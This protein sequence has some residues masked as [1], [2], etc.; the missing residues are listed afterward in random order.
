VRVVVGAAFSTQ[1]QQAQQAYTEMMRANPNLTPAIGPLWAQ[2]LDVPHADKLAQVLTAMAP[3]EVQ[4][5]L[6]PQDN[7]PTSEQLMAQLEQMKAALQ[8]AL[9]VA[10]EVQQE[11]AQL[12]AEA[13]AKAAEMQIKA[14]EVGVKEYDAQT[15]RMTAEN[16]AQQQ[17][18]QL[19]LAEQEPPEQPEMPEEAEPEEKPEPPAPQPIV[20][21]VNVDARQPTNGT[22]HVLL[23][24]DELG[25]VVGGSVVPDEMMNEGL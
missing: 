1:R 13:E 15:K 17:A 11:C 19:L 24:R 6:K 2:T 9:G 25:R 16:Q 18:A 12:K 14:R 3:P 10:Q 4:A 8:E 22:K 5:I 23:Q 20:V 21:H 7:M